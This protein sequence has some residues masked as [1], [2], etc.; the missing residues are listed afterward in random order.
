MINW[1]VNKMIDY[2]VTYSSNDQTVKSVNDNDRCNHLNIH[3]MKYEDSIYPLLFLI[4]YLLHITPKI[5]TDNT[6]R[7]MPDRC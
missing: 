7:S 4:D 1:S 6:T 3:E 2:N 5:M